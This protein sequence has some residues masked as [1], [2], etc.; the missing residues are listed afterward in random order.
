MLTRDY[1]GNCKHWIDRRKTKNGKV[2]LYGRCE[3]GRPFSQGKI[4]GGKKVCDIK[5]RTDIACR[6]HVR[7]EEWK[8]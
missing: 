8:E 7:V 3:M 5:I 2:P 1:C 6:D 4:R